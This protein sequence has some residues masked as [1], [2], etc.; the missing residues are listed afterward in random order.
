MEASRASR[1]PLSLVAAAL[2][3]AASS[4]AST[5]CSCAMRDAF[6]CAA[7]STISSKLTIA[8]S[9]R[10][11]NATNSPSSSR[12]SCRSCTSRACSERC[13][14]SAASRSA[15]SCESGSVASVLP[16]CASRCLPRIIS[17]SW[18]S[19]RSACHS[20]EIP[21]CG[22]CTNASA[23]PS[24]VNPC[25]ARSGE[26]GKPLGEAMLLLKHKFAR[27]VT[28]TCVWGLGLEAARSKGGRVP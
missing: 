5:D 28:R 10:R 17:R 19:T 13:A 24:N 22:E 23:A 3:L 7:R 20:L 21:C 6:S 2:W 8:P 12:F 26:Y 25:V 16:R 15:R 4:C 14:C 11:L 18:C 1:S 27:K 9:M